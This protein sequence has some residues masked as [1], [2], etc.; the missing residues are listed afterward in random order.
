M[1]ERTDVP[2]S[3]QAILTRIA[4]SL[5]ELE[6]RYGIHQMDGLGCIYFESRDF[7]SVSLYRSNEGGWHV[8]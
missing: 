1:S 5:D 6:S 3:A 7:G 4:N 2:D 8:V